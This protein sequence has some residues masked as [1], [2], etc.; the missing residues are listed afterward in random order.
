MY[1]ILFHS[2]QTL[3]QA[4]ADI[5]KEIVDSPL[6][7]LFINFLRQSTRGLCR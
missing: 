7:V 3:P 1:K 2:T 6:R 5:E 4:I